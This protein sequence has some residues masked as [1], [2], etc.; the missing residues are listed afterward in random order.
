LRDEGKRAQYDRMRAAGFGVVDLEEDGGM[1]GYGTPWGQPSMD[2][3]DFD[4]HF[5]E[6]W[7]KMS[8]E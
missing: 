4:K 8:E 7:K 5:D 2:A 3:R 6:W 1:G